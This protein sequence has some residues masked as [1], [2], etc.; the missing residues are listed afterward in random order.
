MLAYV[1]IDPQTEDGYN[2]VVKAE[3]LTCLR[4]SQ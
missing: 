2:R 3:E 4:E 1:T